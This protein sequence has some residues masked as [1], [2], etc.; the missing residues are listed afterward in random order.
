MGEK[1]NTELRCTGD[2]GVECLEQRS[3]QGM[4]RGNW[5]GPGNF[6]RE[7]G[8]GLLKFLRQNSV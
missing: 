1:R 3:L 2:H 5:K 7:Y 6:L 4:K 8:A